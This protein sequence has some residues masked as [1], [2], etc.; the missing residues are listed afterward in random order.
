MALTVFF[1]PCTQMPG[2]FFGA[3]V[4]VT[5]AGL[6]IHTPCLSRTGRVLLRPGST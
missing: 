3:P 4:T 6:S 1:G 2:V 5:G